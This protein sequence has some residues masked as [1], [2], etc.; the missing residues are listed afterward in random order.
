[1]KL[2]RVLTENVNYQDI[3][4]Y[5]DDHFP[6]GYTIVQANGAW[7]G[8]REKS[9]IIEILACKLTIMLQPA[10]DGLAYWLKKHNKQEAVL[11]E[12]INVDVQY[13]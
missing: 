4:Q 13:L 11:V 3:L 7:Q 12:I 2:Y 6:D 5:L 1:M 10:I 8:Q 9:L